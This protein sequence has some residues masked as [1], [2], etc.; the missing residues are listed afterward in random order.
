[1]QEIRYSVVVR[2]ISGFFVGLKEL[3]AGQLYKN[4]Q[5]MRQ[6]AAKERLIADLTRARLNKARMRRG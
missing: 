1:M 4:Q 2:Q 3:G 5:G 6:P